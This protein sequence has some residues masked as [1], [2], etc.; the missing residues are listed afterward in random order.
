VSRAAVAVATVVAFE[1]VVANVVVAGVAGVA[2]GIDVIMM[3][4]QLW[5]LKLQN[6]PNWRVSLVVKGSS[7]SCRRI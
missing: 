3:L 4:I 7:F 2:D 6:P 1:V 5:K